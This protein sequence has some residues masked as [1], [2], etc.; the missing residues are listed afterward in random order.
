MRGPDLSRLYDEHAQPL[1]AFLLNLTRDEAGTRDL[2]Q[3]IFVKI[4]RDPE[5]LAGVRDER[6]FLIRLAHNAAIDLIRRRGTRDK[7]RENFAAETISPFAPASDPDEQI[8]R[9]ALAGALAELPPDQCAV[10][11]L[12]LWEGLT[13][14]QIADALDIPLNTAASRYRY[15]LDK[16]RERLRPLYEE[17][18]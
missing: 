9:A 14:E 7:T 17:I 15:G 16:L 13:F 1:Y 6:A 12:K 10:V 18:K 2:L 4:A 3:D 8:F 11:H 5:L